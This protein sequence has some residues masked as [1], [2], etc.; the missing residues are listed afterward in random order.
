[1]S[2]P[3]ARPRTIDDLPSRSVVRS[4][5][6]AQIRRGLPEF[7]CLLLGVSS[8]AL[9]AYSYYHDT[10][11]PLAHSFGIWIALAVLASSPDRIQRSMLRASI[12]LLAATTSFYVGKKIY[13]GY[14]YPG[15]PY[16]L[17]VGYT[18]AWGTAAIV[19][20]AALG[21]LGARLHR[22]GWLAAAATASVCALIAVDAYRTESRDGLLNNVGPVAPLAVV[23]ISMI[24]LMG[25]RSVRHLARIG[26][27]VPPA[28]ALSYA[29]LALPDWAEQMLL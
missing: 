22:R 12:V 23:A 28:I 6:S 11:R 1:M 8:G 26:I 17:D 2:E 3:E 15:M 29:I 9:G 10:W 14:L 20:G 27:L 13:Y 19:A 16:H 7:A 24:V 5:Q 25:P 18:I 21:L 4:L